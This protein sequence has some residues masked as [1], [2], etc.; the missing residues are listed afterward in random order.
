MGIS[1]I[2]RPLKSFAREKI[3]I[4]LTTTCVYCKPLLV[5]CPPH[6]RAKRSEPKGLGRR[7]WPES[8]ALLPQ[9]PHQLPVPLVYNIT[10]LA[11]QI[12]SD[13]QN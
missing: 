13:L 1:Q 10:R 9:I 12:E 6:T 3:G 2:V 7:T 5:M 8:K 4:P 11:F